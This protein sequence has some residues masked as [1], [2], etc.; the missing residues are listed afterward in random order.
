VWRRLAERRSA[1]DEPNEYRILRLVRDS[2]PISRTEISQRC[3]LS[4]TTVTEIVGRFLDVGFLEP[5]GAGSSTSRGGRKR[6]LLQ[7]NP[8]AGTVFGIDI[9]MRSVQLVAT[10]LNANILHRSSFEITP[11]DHPSEV[12]GMITEHLDAWR[13]R[14][15]EM[16]DQG[17]GIGIGLPGIIDRERGVIRVADTLKGWKGTNLRTPFHERFGLPVFVENDVKTM[18]IAEYLFGAG[19][20][21]SDQVFFWVGDGIGAG[22][23]VDG[24]VLHGRT[25]SAGEIGYNEVGHLLSQPERFPLLYRGQSDLGGLLGDASLLQAYRSA[26]GRG[27]IGTVTELASAARHEDT[28]ALQVLDE[29]T[30]V[31][32]TVGISIVNLLNPELIILGGSIASDPSLALRVQDKLGRDRLSE[33]A[34][35][36]SVRPSLLGS[37]GVV[38]G[39]VGL[40]LYDLF[41]P[42]RVN[43]VTAESKS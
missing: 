6:E 24:K 33:P 3:A 28:V 17:V 22:I 23:I 31:I 4:K 32:A 7:F 34:T 14:F 15:P 38:M 12:I 2:S 1:F 9:R 40:V 20:H 18:T 43:G 35:A 10:D 26:G 11:G 19:K 42:A 36:V 29:A 37:D 30:T 8:K 13:E 5:V 27:T 39:A 41:K 25:A 16:F 21:V